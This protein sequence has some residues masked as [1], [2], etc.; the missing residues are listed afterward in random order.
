MKNIIKYKFLPLLILV[1]TFSFS[2]SAKDTT[3]VYKTSV[4]CDMCKDRIER[5]LVFEKGV[6]EVTVNIEKKLVTVKYNMDKT[7]SLKIKKA[8]SKMGYRADD[9]AADPKGFKKLPKCCQA[10]GCGKD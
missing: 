2:A 3:Q 1:L 8:I 5:E 9:I 7:T 10:E 6:K 4:L